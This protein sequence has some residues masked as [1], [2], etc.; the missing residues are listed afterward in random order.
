LRIDLIINAAAPESIE[1]LR[2]EVTRLRALGHD[3]HPHLTFESG[4]ACDFAREAAAAGT[5]LVIAAGGDGTLNEAANG[6]HEYLT[7]RGGDGAGPAGEEIP[8]LAVLPL[9]TA[10][11]LA[12]T[13]GIPSG[14]PD[15]IEVALSGEAAEIDVALVNGR[16]FLNVSTGGFGAEATEETSAEAKNALGTLAYLIT[17]VRKFVN[18]EPSPGRFVSDELLYDGPFLLFAVGNSRQT[19][20]GNLLTP[21]ADPDDGFL[22]V[23]I[24]KEM[25]R[26]A[27]LG[28]L[29]DLHAGTHLEHESVLYHRVPRLLVESDAPISVNA[30]GEALHGTTFDYGISPHRLRLVRPRTEAGSAAA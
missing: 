13:L 18:L 12:N 30:D 5:S 4:D 29:P 3:V 6:V 8:R 10:N 25:S 23:C 7:E 20:G 1:A 24:V 27:F 28:L 9:G 11:D 2:S 19:G 21:R 15:A 16:C 26:V 14:I 17:G 22:D